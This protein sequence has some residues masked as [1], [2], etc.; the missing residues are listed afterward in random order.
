[1]SSGCAE[2][3]GG[4]GTLGG[5]ETVPDIEEVNTS[6]YVRLRDKEY[7]MNS[8]K[9]KEGQNG[10]VQR[11][12]CRPRQVDRTM[13]YVALNSINIRCIHQILREL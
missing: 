12:Q 9:E 10:G 3:S 2:T 11:A 8:K 7:K 6:R 13:I 4:G 1:M 5:S